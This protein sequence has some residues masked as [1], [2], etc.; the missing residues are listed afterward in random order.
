MKISLALIL[1]LLLSL[2]N[3][4]VTQAAFKGIPFSPEAD[5]RFNALETGGSIGS[6]TVSESKLTVPTANGLNASRKARVQYSFATV[7]G[8]IGA[9]PLG[10]TLPA[11]AIIVRSYIYT[12][13]AITGTSSTVALSCGVANNIFS[14][15]SMTSITAGT[16][17]EGVSTGAAT[18]FKDVG[19]AACAVTATIATANVTAGKF[20]VWIDYVVHD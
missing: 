2:V 17:T 7:G 8:T 3:V 6:G 1:L 4:G 14:A 20:T 11:H 18:V 19:A 10:V 15:A 5:A 9:I 13:A 16:F 12:D